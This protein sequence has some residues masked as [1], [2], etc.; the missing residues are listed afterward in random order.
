[1]TGM[2]IPHP[3]T[4]TSTVIK[5]NPMAAERVVFMSN[6][7]CLLQSKG[8]FPMHPAKKDM[9]PIL[10]VERPLVAVNRLFIPCIWAIRQPSMIIT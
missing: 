5:I 4:S 2:M 3:I 1:M 7:K 10:W 9:A 6:K 8:I